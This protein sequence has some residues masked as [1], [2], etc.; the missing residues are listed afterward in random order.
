MSD[1]DQLSRDLPARIAA[2]A[3]LPA[4]EAERVLALGR[5]GTVTALLKT[6]GGMSAEER[7]VQGPRIHA[8][9][10]A[11]TGAIAELTNC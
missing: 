5:H 2:A 6:L 1:L 9:R 11:V 8:L 7:Q 4:L 3:D 10:E